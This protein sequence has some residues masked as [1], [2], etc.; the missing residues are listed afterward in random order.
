[1][2]LKSL[3]LVSVLAVT[4][5]SAT[6]QEVGETSVGG[7]IT[8]FGLA[9]QGEY[10]IA[11]NMGARAMI[12]GGINANDTIEVDDYTVD[13]DLELGGLAAFFDYYPLAN[14]WR[15]SGG[16]MLSNSEL[17]GDFVGP[18]LFTGTIALTNDVAPVITTGFKTSIA[19]G[20]SFSGDVGVVIS[21]LEA[22]TDSNDPAVQDEIDTLN[23]D[24]SDVPVLPYAGIA[25][26]YS[27]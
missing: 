19:P 3:A 11:P 18:E 20:W 1:M 5:Q 27:F 13:G 4:A 17:S 21:S 12:M 26:S 25:I 6:A 15:I 14:A 16:L 22:S 24:L 9:L 2:Y 23:D 8:T 7:G 10:S